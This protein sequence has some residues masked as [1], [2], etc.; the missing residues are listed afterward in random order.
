MRLVDPARD[1]F[2]LAELDFSTPGRWA[3]SAV[4]PTQSVVGAAQS[5]V[6][7]TPSAWE[8]HRVLFRPPIEYLM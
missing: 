6:E 8:V 3:Q 1:L 2:Y 4:P 5:A 7:L